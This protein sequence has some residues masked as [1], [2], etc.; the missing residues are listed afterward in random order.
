MLLLSGVYYC[1]APILL[2]IG[3]F[4]LILLDRA[5]E[6]E[7][8]L[9]AWSLLIV[10]VSFVTIGFGVMSI[11]WNKYRLTLG[12]IAL[13]IVSFLLLTLYQ[14]LIIFG[15]DDNEKFL[16]YSALFLS[17]NVVFMSIFIFMDNFEGYEDVLTLIKKH[18]RDGQPVDHKSINNL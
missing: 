6:N 9:S 10:G 12:G 13:F 14:C 11:K 5:Q 16:P 4:V 3:W 8:T 18:F 1:I 2:L 17:F 7:S 15:Y